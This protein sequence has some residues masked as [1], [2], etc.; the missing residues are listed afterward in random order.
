[1]FQYKVK[2][3]NEDPKQALIEK[4]GITAE[5]TLE[6]VEAQ[7]KAWE[8]TVTELDAKVRVEKAVMDNI[9]RN[10][11]FVSQLDPEHLH[12]YYMYFKSKAVVVEG[13]KKLVE[14]REAIEESKKERTLIEEVINTNK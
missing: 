7:E 13:E 10:Y 6:Q 5:F 11:P 3:P 14:W 8:K 9:E 12:A 4:A 1:M 2:E